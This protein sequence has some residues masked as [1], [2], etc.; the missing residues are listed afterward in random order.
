MLL[1]DSDVFSMAHG[2]E[3][4][5]P[6]LDHEFVAATTNLPGAW[7]RPKQCPKPLLVDAVGQ[8]LPRR[9]T[10]QKKRGFTFPWADWLRKDLASVASDRLADRSIWLNIGFDASI[11]L[12]FWK[13][14]QAND[15]AI[16]G[17]HILGL[18]VLADVAARQGLSV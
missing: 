17:S 6:L 14:F 16:G 1:R 12:A 13:R 9:V 15:P 18:I 2:L 10:T 8:R 5:V 7:K 11:P 3:L 4:R